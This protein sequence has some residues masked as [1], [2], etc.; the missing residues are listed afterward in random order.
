M[1]GIALGFTSKTKMHSPPLGESVV[2]GR[3]AGEGSFGDGAQCGLVGC[4]G[5]SP[6]LATRSQW[7]FYRWGPEGEIQTGLSN[8]GEKA[9]QA[10]GTALAKT[11]TP[12]AS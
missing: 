7:C 8:R 6:G 9:F 10:G 2:L 3:Q 1:L 12:E 11:A 5:T 4:R